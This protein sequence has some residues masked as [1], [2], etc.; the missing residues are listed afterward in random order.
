[1]PHA[2][3]PRPLNSQ[4]LVYLSLSYFLWLP[5]SSPS[6]IWAAWGLQER[7]ND[8]GFMI[9]QEKRCGQK[10]E[11]TDEEKNWGEE[12][13]REFGEEANVEESQQ[14]DEEEREKNEMEKV[15]IE[16]RES[17]CVQVER[18]DGG[19]RHSEEGQ[20]CSNCWHSVRDSDQ[21]IIF[22]QTDYLRLFVVLKLCEKWRGCQNICTGECFEERR[23]L[24]SRFSQSK[25]NARWCLDD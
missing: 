21:Q 20:S 10:G 13:R 19:R 11:G 12:K 3:P 8:C 15:I 25:I 9:L 14:R 6:L 1:M 24:C 7:T 2:Y 16:N 18:Q 17:S 23:L 4:L 22:P 5:P